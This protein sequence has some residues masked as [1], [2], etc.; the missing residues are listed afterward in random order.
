MGEMIPGARY[1]ELPGDDHTPWFGDSDP[2]LEE[3]EEFL[4]AEGQ[5]YAKVV[6]E[7]RQPK[8]MYQSFRLYLKRNPE[9]A[10]KV[11][12]HLVAGEL[13]LERLD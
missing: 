11:A 2:L 7:G 8:N 13:Y 12:V 4:K 6:I 5:R 10:E 3:I 1:V 9:V